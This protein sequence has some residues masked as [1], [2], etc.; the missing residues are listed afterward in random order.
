MIRDNLYCYRMEVT[1]VIDGDTIECTI[2]CGLFTF[3]KATVRILGIDAPEMKKE[4]RAKG[5]ESRQWLVDLCDLSSFFFIRTYKDLQTDSFGR[6]LGELE[7][8]SGD[9]VAK[10][11]I[12][13]GHAKPRAVVRKSK[14]K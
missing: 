3:K 13:A 1:R 4:T 12:A 10:M 8:E 6:W 9:S 5:I 2:D 14:P 11:M 7:T